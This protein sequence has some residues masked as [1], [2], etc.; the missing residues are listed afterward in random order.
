MF[1]GTTLAHFVPFFS[2]DGFERAGGGRGE[3]TSVGLTLLRGA[4]YV[5]VAAVKR[6]ISEVWFLPL[7]YF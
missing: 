7:L 5:S 1:S 4:D 6:S 3:S 2:V